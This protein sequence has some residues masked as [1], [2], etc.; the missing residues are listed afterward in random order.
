MDNKLLKLHPLDKGVTV[1]V[2]PEDYERLSKW[3]WYLHSG[4]YAV[5]IVFRRIGYKEYEK[6][7][8]LMHREIMNT[9]Q[10]LMTDHING[11]KLDNRKDNLRICTGKE[12]QGNRKKQASLYS[13]YL[14]VTWCKQHRLW[15]AQL[16][17][18]SKSLNIGLFKS[19]HHAALARDLWAKD[20]FG[21]FATLNFRSI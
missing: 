11:N 2:D 1:V 10:G 6:K 15:K 12:N 7:A 9:P 17:I 4:G 16:G 13:K 14:G 20:Y 21:K 8:V 18:K 19:E 5:R 3:K